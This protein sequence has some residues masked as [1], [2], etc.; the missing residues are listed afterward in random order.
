MSCVNLQRNESILIRSLW[1][2]TVVVQINLNVKELLVLSDVLWENAQSVAVLFSGCGLILLEGWLLLP[3]LSFEVVRISL[4][5]LVYQT[6]A[7]SIWPK[8]KWSLSIYLETETFSTSFK[9]PSLF[10]LLLLK[11][12]KLL[13]IQGPSPQKLLRTQRCYWDTNLV[14]WLDNLINGERPLT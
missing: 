12:L 8:T 1:K 5:S 10:L 4:L 6:V 9:Q 13:I 3:L 7:L 14:R 11:W 2:L